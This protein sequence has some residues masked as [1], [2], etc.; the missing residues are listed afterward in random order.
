MEQIITQIKQ[1]KPEATITLLSLPDG[2]SMNTMWLNYGTH[3]VTEFLNE[4][5][6]PEPEERGLIIHSPQKISYNSKGLTYIIVGQLSMDLGN[7]RVALNIVV[8]E[9]QRKHRIKVDLSDFVSV[10]DRCKELSEKHGLDSHQLEADFNRIADLLELYKESLFE[11]EM[12]D[13]YSEKELTPRAMEK[14]VEF[15]QNPRLMK[16]IDSLLEKTGIIG[17]EDNRNVLFVV[18]SGYKMPYPLHCMVQGTSGGGKS[19]LINAIAECMPQEDLLDMTR[20]TSK[21]LYHYR[22]KELVNKLVVI[23]D[24]DGLDDEAQFAFREIQTHKKLSSSTAIKDALGN[25]RGKIKTVHAHFASLV[26]TTRAELYLD[27]MSRSVMLGI[28]ESEAQTL[29]IIKRQNQKKAG[30]SNRDE[31]QEAK[32]LIRN[33]MRVLKSLQVVNPFA[34]KLM[35]PLEAKMLRRLNEQFQDF[36]C[37]ITLLHQYQRKTDSQ[38]RL[39]ATKED[40]RT[41]VE[42]FFSAIILKVDELDASTRQF[43]ESIKTYVKS[44][45]KGTTYK[46]TALEIRQAT[47]KEKSTANRY[48]K[49]LQGL[50]YIQQVEG[51]ANKGFKY[52]ISYFDDMEKLKAR[53][54]QELN[55]QLDEL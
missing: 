55:R 12:T 13:L 30:L 39:I 26:A 52:V 44:Q 17:E 18:T 4:R 42:L 48:I 51:A 53:V 27:N 35:L 40:I 23:Q 28:D 19:H 37:Q 8:D 22:D 29:R 1:L 32:Q 34:D 7:F 41:A 49:T 14:A 21:S 15:L 43:F 36:V 5:P 50:E 11:D 47:N 45:T 9:T 20:I 31:E 33:C 6:K 2:D 25:T 10:E 24:F 54:K 16:N 3:G 38:G 46:F